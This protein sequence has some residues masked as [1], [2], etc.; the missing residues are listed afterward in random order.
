MNASIPPSSVNYHS[1][2]DSQ[3]GII[4]RLNFTDCTEIPGRTP[5]STLR[6]IVVDVK[7]NE[8]KISVGCVRIRRYARLSVRN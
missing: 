7:A 1:Q 4:T 8:R 3:A 5:L 2:Y 6:L